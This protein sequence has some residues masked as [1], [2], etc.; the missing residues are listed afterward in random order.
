MLSEYRHLARLL[1]KIKEYELILVISLVVILV[2]GFSL[3]GR[4]SSL[5][6]QN[7][8]L[9]ENFGKL[10]EN[11]ESIR[12]ADERIA[13]LVTE[14]ADLKSE[15][16]ALKL[17]NSNNSGVA[18]NDGDLKV[19]KVENAKL[20]EENSALRSGYAKLYASHGVLEKTVTD[21]KEKN[22]ELES[23]LVKQK[24]ARTDNDFLRSENSRLRAENEQLKNRNNLLQLEIVRA[25]ESTGSGAGQ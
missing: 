11:L 21:M 10:K 4:L 1:R 18:V 6:T 5:K 16:A 17:K 14:V 8:V 24:G 20:I 19:L 3:G 7:A 12:E 13:E 15:N 2:L 25:F 22:A 23:N 9:S